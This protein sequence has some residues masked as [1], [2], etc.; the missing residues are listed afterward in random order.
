MTRKTVLAKHYGET[1]NIRQ[2]ILLVELV[3]PMVFGNGSRYVL[4]HPP[5]LGHTF[6]NLAMVNGE[7]LDL[8]F[9]N[10][11]GFDPKLSHNIFDAY[12]RFTGELP[13]NVHGTGMGLHISRQLARKMEG[14]VEASSEGKGNGAQLV[15]Y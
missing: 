12:R 2:Y 1:D 8:G 6:A 7:H 4:R 9:D 14:D 3:H 10:G 5:D 11:S 15:L 13:E